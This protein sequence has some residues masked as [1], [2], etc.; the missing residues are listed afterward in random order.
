[1]SIENLI[2]SSFGHSFDLVGTIVRI[3]GSQS[4]S[5]EEEPEMITLEGFHVNY[6]GILPVQFEPARIEIPNNPYRKLNWAMPL[7]SSNSGSIL[8]EN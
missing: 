8:V 1:M 5:L 4:G 6:S 7:T 3:S 2:S